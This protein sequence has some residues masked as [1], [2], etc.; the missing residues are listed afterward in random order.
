MKI[1]SFYFDSSVRAIQFL[2]PS[3][4]I[5][6]NVTDLGVNYCL[7]YIMFENVGFSFAHWKVFYFLYFCEFYRVKIYKL[8]YSYLLHIFLIT[9][10]RK[11][12]HEPDFIAKLSKK[13]RRKPASIPPRLCKVC[14]DIVNK[15][16]AAAISTLHT[17]ENHGKNFYYC[18]PDLFTINS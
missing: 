5:Y 11:A 6:T 15:C 1:I 12:G 2:N 13:R 10:K 8:Q 9:V 14:V 16:R 18:T 4:Y 17:N 7:K 3:A